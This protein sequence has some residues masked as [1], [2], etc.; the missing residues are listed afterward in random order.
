LR[1]LWCLNLQKLDAWRAL[2]SYP[3]SEI[4]TGRW[5]CWHLK[6]H[7][8]KAYLFTGS[9]RLDFFDLRTETW[10][11][12]LT[13]FK[14]T[15][16]DK[17][18][19][20]IM[21]AWPYPERKCSE[22][23]Q[24]LV[25]NKLYVFGGRHGLTRLG[26]SLFMELDLETMR[27]RRLSGALMPVKADYS[28]PGPRK[29]PSSWVNKDQD[30]IYLVF[31]ESDREAA[32]GTGDPNAATSGYAYE[33]FWSYGIK[34]GKWRMERFAGNV[35]CP[36]SEA[37]CTYVS[38]FHSLLSILSHVFSSLESETR[39]SDCIRGVQPCPPYHDRAR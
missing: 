10:S 19:G 39:Q 37:A 24:E 7:R 17:T 29:T 23:A 2:P 28:C 11:S 12:V 36:R 27:W 3:V 14:A 6:V 18:E 25:G 13:T 1:D 8:D 32:Q 31:G 33:D 35:P 30:R 9:P 34:E 22:S 20:Y 26:C 15:K 4:L 16:A 21:D 5:M 38:Q